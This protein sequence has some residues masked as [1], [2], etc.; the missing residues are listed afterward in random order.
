MNDIKGYY[1][2]LEITEE[3]KKNL[4]PDELTKKIRK[5]FRRLSLE[6]HPD[7]FANESEQ[8]RNKHEE[9]FKK[10]NEAY[11]VIGEKEKREKYDFENEGFGA[12]GGFGFEGFRHGFNPFGDFNFRTTMFSRGADVKIG[13]SITLEE[14][15]SG[16]KKL[17]AITRKMRQPD[18]EGI[19]N[20]VTTNEYINIPRGAEDGSIIKY[21]GRGSESPYSK[22]QNGDLIIKFTVRKHPKFG[23]IGNN[24]TTDLEVN[25]LEA[26]DGADKE[27]MTLSGKKLI[28]TVPA[29][30]PYGKQFRLSG[31]G[32]PNVNGTGFGDLIVRIVY[33]TP[34]VL[35][36]KQVDLLREFYEIENNKK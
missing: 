13:I 23:R 25:L 18:K 22:G 33:K 17:Y 4:S 15:M 32:L 2:I 10:V 26:F 35:T 8:V 27:V 21:P 19:L 7:K 31:N 34:K 24:L 11:S 20:N 3:D 16:S 6:N 30:T 5:N 28:M 1:K 12:F 29:M 9:T 14:V 36:Q